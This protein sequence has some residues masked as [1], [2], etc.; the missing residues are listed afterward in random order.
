MPAEDVKGPDA[1]PDRP[2]HSFRR[3]IGLLTGL[4]PEEKKAVRRSI[5]EAGGG[6]IRFWVLLVLSTFIAAFGLVTNSA[7]VIIGAMIIAPLMGPI[8]ASAL[9][10]DA[11]D[12]RL[13]GKA[14]GAEVLGA[15]VAI[16]IGYLVGI[17]PFDLGV[18]G[19]MLARTTPTLYD[20]F[21]AAAC[22][23][24]GAYATIDQKVSN[25][26]AGVAISV[27]L[28]PPLAACGLF[29]SLGELSQAWGAF[30]LFLANFLA[31]QIAAGIVFFVYGVAD[32]YE[33]KGASLKHLARFT[34][35]FV[36][37]IAVGAF[38]TST[39][40]QV[41]QKRAFESNLNR[42]LAAEIGARTGGQLEDV[43]IEGQGE[44]GFEV[45]AIALTPQPFDPA[46]VALIEDKLR[47]ECRPDVRLIIRSLSSS[48]ADRNGQV[49]LTQSQV[50]AILRQKEDESQIAR[51][52]DVLKRAL[53]QIPG[54]TLVN[55]QRSETMGGMNVSAVVR[56]PVAIAPRQVADMEQALAEAI[57]GRIRLTVRS[58]LTREADA[59]RYLYEVT[60]DEPVPSAE[61]RSRRRRIE[62]ILERKLTRLEGAVLRELSIEAAGERVGVIAYVDAPALISPEQVAEYQRDLRRYAGA[63]IDLTVRTTQIGSAS[64]DGWLR[65]DR[66]P[67][68]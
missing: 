66:G 2:R 28:V 40:I 19:E 15:A 6:S 9:A 32:I 3:V 48:D 39:L 12:M 16:F 29:L 23:L 26:L 33:L 53:M 56:T 45:I 24:A 18:S 13:L 8:V 51:A 61:E 10:I 65:P 58:V 59:T 50:G 55:V 44:N 27:A 1:K 17:L 30:M 37:L 7:A 20:L 54:A 49:F 60:E 62:S 42:V 4:G 68:G 63:T 47:K 57:G 35:S 67:A 36:I 34:P 25:A 14:L 64:A 31:I 43:I 22:G 11:G 5:D 52:T 21:I 38:M 46:Q 41:A